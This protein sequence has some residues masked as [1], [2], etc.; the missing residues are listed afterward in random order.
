VVTLPYWVKLVRSGS[1]FTGFASPD[2]VNWAQ[3]GASQ[4]INMA[5]NVYVGLAVSSND[6]SRLTTATFD[7]VSITSP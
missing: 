6:T 4:S 3:V 2:G 5:P 1:T 7:N